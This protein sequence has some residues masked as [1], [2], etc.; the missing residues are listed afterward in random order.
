MEEEEEKSTQLGG[1]GRTA[2]TDRSGIPHRQTPF[3]LQPEKT[4]EE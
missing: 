3:F 4:E 1:G 2:G